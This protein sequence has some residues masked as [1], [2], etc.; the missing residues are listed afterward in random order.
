M[1]GL[2]LLWGLPLLAP[3]SSTSATTQTTTAD[4][5]P[6]TSS[7][8]G[9]PSQG[10][11]TSSSNG[12]SA[13][14]S[15]TSEI[16]P[17]TITSYTTSDTRAIT[18]PSSTTFDISAVTTLSSTTLITQT[19][20]AP[21][22]HSTIVCTVESSAG[23]GGWISVAGVV[24]SVVVAV[25]LTALVSSAVTYYI[26]RRKYPGKSSDERTSATTVG[27]TS[28][29]LPEERHDDVTAKP[30]GPDIDTVYTGTDI[31]VERDRVND[32]ETRKTELDDIS[33]IDLDHSE[34][35]V[36]AYNPLTMVEENVD[37]SSHSE[38]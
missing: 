37:D 32:P 27:N 2:L 12:I 24:G 5:T 13:T 25:V 20:N 9:T 31:T 8:P 28:N 29:S 1:S 4:I 7:A 22:D 19:S 33:V 10:S 26:I 17:V 30:H 21:G 14:S 38:L 18:T 11:P 6:T 35:L 23:D 3:A 15:S 36:F 16:T 34:R